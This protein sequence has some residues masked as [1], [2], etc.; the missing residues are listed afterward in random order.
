MKKGQFYLFTALILIASLGIILPRTGLFNA[1]TTSLVELRA[2]LQTE[3]P[4]AI[5]AAI[6]NN[7]NTTAAFSE[8]LSDFHT[9][10]KEREPSIQ[11]AAAYRHEGIYVQSYFHIPILVDG[12]RLDGNGMFQEKESINLTINGTTHILSLPSPHSV[13]AVLMTM[14]GQRVEVV[15]LG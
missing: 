11:M 9:F 4:R 8:F 1:P 10:A 3:A 13:A 12:V 15:T 14:N 6:T 7:T 5:N 2:N